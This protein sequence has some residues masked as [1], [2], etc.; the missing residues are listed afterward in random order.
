M[1]LKGRVL[2]NIAAILTGI[3]IVLSVPGLGPE[4]QSVLAILVVSMVLWFSE[5]MPLHATAILAAFLLVAF[6]GFSP[7]EVYSP[8]FDPVIVLL[9]GGFVLARALQKHGLDEYIALKFLHK[10]GTSPSRFLLGIMA[11]TAFLSMWISNTASTAVIL[12]IGIVI[13]S[14]NG[15]KPLK[16]NFGKALILGIAFSATIGG[17]GTLVGSTPNVIAAKFLNENG[18]SFGFTDWM[19]HGIPLVIVMVP[20]LWVVLKTVYKPEI[21]KLKAI[22][23]EKNLDGKQKGVLCIFA[24]TVAMWLTTGLH[25]IPSNTVSL[26]PIILLYLTGLLDTGD[27]S[28]INWAALILIGGGLTLGLSISAVGLDVL[29]ANLIEFLVANQPVFLVFVTIGLFAIALT[30]FAS[31]T[32]AA[33]VMIPI[34]IPLA[35]NL[36]LDPRTVVVLAGIGVSLDFIV[37]VGTPPS[38]IAYSSGFVR[39]KDMV[40]VGVLLAFIGVVALA[41]LAMLYW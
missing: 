15:L 26:I 1:E 20:I 8:F 9:L 40:R 35:L 30:I 12:P 29:F 21:R 38:A 13:L 37:P 31:N 28:K 27:F 33:A 22:P 4:Q 14:R 25:G 10:T 3:W 18:I 5:L 32:A 24:L 19:Y 2:L 6:A 16:S 11:V 17:I 41:G 36:G 39:V 7:A 23:F 34:M